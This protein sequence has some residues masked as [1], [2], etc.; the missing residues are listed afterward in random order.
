[1]PTALELTREEWKKYMMDDVESIPPRKLTTAE[2]RELDNLMGRVRQAASELKQRYGAR[3]VVVFGSL[4][5]PEWFRSDSDVD[6][7]VEGVGEH[8]W[9]AWGLA[10]RIIRDRSVDFVEIESATPALLRFIKR[11][12]IDL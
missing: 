2:Q 12:G 11:D 10:E 4:A 9:D 8:Y 6:L 1:M 5:Q 3:R 7:A